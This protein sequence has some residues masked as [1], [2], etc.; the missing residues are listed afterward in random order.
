MVVP[1]D[2]TRLAFYIAVR[3][4]DW[5]RP[6]SLDEVRDL[7]VRA[8]PLGARPFAY[9]AI[10]SRI[11][12]PCGP[13]SEPAFV[14][15]ENTTVAELPAMGYIVLSSETGAILGAADGYALESVPV[16]AYVIDSPGAAVYVPVSAYVIDSPGAVVYV[17]E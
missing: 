11:T 9:Y 14:F 2:E 17:P 13:A 10:P 3:G 12:V 8:T 1:V 7:A 5:S 6:L 4:M 16:S 15:V